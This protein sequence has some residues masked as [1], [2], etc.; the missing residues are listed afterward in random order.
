MPIAQGK[1]AVWCEDNQ[2]N[3]V[4]GA[5]QMLYWQQLTGNNIKVDGNDLSGEPKSPAY[6][7]KCGFE[8]GEG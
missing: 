5:K 4:K 8:D 6:N 2:S 1:T 3:C 7:T